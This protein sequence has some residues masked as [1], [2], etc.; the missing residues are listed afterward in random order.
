M[1][2]E[3]ITFLDQCSRGVWSAML[4]LFGLFPI[5]RRLTVIGE[6]VSNW[7][8]GARHVMDQ[9]RTISSPRRSRRANSECSD[10]QSSTQ[11]ALRATDKLIYARCA[12]TASSVERYVPS[13]RSYQANQLTTISV[14]NH[15]MNQLSLRYT[16]TKSLY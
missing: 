9:A 2:T 3:P 6:K 8:S 14:Q 4:P 13:F 10:K 16:V 7:A 5:T 11:S 1:K 15:R 12:T